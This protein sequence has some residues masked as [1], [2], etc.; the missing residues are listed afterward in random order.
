MSLIAVSMLAMP[1][2]RGQWKVIKLAD[3]TEIRAELKGD[4]FCSYWQATD[5]RKFVENIRN[6]VFEQTDMARLEAV[7]APMRAASRMNRNT[8]PAARMP[9]GGDH[10]PYTGKKKGLIILVEFTNKKFEAAHTRELFNRIANEEG[11]SEMNFRGSVKDYFKEQ[12]YGQFEL[13][14]DVVGPVAMKQRYGFYGAPTADG[15]NDNYANVARMVADACRAVDGEV[16]FNDYDWDGDGEADQVF[17][18]YA[19]HGQADYDDVNTIWPH[20][21]SIQALS[22]T[23]LVLDGVK[24]DT[25]ACS[26]ELNGSGDIYGIGAM[27]H[28]FSHCLGLPDVYDTQGTSGYGTWSWDLMD[29]GCYNGNAYVPASYTSYERMYAGWLK[30]TELTDDCEVSA[31]KGLNDG[32]EAYIIYNDGNRDEYYLLENRQKTGWDAELPGAGLLVLHVDFNAEAWAKNVV[33]SLAGQ[34]I[35]RIDPVHKRCVLIPADNNFLTS[36]AA[37]GGDAYPYNGNNCLTNTS[38]PAASVYNKNTDGSLYMNKPVT[39]ITQNAD[40]TV[41][42]SFRN[43]NR[44]TGIGNVTADTADRRIYSLDGRYMG[45][46]LNVLKSGVYIVGGKKVVK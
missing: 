43:E 17:I 35:Y 29:Y 25:Y 13:D 28:E 46:D 3:G 12:S 34:E 21:S 36:P 2:K 20:S 23:N 32:G 38:S 7:A 19:G 4:E 24:I 39:G 6:G 9:I 1:A 22:G 31:M 45:K 37:V 27:C 42:F 5:G 41:S 11:F 40:G 10:E 44:A 15:Q 16:D 26:C 8:G 33:N 18:I 30:P 14:F